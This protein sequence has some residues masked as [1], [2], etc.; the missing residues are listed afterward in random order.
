MT[1]WGHDLWN[2]LSQI[3]MLHTG[4]GRNCRRLVVK[5]P[6]HVTFGQ[7]MHATGLMEAGFGIVLFENLVCQ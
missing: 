3:E 5:S 7:A 2:I 6:G 1:V 4:R